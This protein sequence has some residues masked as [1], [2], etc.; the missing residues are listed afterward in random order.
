MNAISNKQNYNN[1]NLPCDGADL[2]KE[3]GKNNADGQQDNIK[4]KDVKEA[5]I[6]RVEKGVE[7]L[8]PQDVGQKRENG[9]HLKQ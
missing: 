4:S 3:Y 6:D 5:R 1:N 7:K 2:R 9:R 8:C